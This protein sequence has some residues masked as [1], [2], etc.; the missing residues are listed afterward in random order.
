[1]LEGSLVEALQIAKTLRENADYENEFS[2]VRAEALYE[3]AAA[4][5]KRV[6]EILE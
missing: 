3:K 5:F 1:M 2:K 6:N 4:L